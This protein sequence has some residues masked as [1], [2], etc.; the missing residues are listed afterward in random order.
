MLQHPVPEGHLARIGDI[1]VSFALIESVIQG[2]A[3]SLLGREQRVGQIVTA[4]L[5]FRGLR[6][7]TLSLYRELRGEEARFHELKALMRRA[8]RL[9]TDRNQIVHSIWAAGEGETVMRIKTTAK[10]KQGFRF[11]FH[12]VTESDL[13]QVADD[14]KELAH[15]IQRFW[16]SLGPGLDESQV[17]E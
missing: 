10:E 14:L 17:T 1:T 11:G 2:L 6:A 8:E 13:R 7:L 16:M 4:E 15:D 5:S 12:P 3:W 9:E